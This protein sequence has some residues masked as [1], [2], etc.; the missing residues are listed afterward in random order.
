VRNR[1]GPLFRLFLSGEMGLPEWD[2]S[3]LC[4]FPNLSIPFFNSGMELPNAANSLQEA[5]S[6]ISINS[7]VAG[8]GTD[9]ADA[10]WCAVS[11]DAL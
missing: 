11:P 4:L 2:L 5:I 8:F 1:P 3:Y 6:T 9:T 7:Y 10:G